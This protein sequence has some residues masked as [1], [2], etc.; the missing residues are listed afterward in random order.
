MG[1]RT[2]RRGTS[3]RRG[4]AAA[5]AA[6]ATAVVLATSGL[7]PA[8]AAEVDT[9]GTFGVS[10]APF[11]GS[12][13]MPGNFPATTFTSTSSA[14]TVISGASTWQAASTPVGSVFGSSRDRTYLTQRPAANNAASPAVTV[15]TFATPTPSSGWAFVLGDIDADEVT[16]SATGPGGA[17]VAVADLGYQESYNSCHRAG[18]PSCDAANLNDRPSWRDDG[19]TG[20]LLGNARAADTDGATAWF[21]PSVPIASLTM[22]YRWR[23]GFPIYQTWFVAKTFSAGGTVTLDDAPLAG[24]TVTVYDDAGTVVGTAVSGASGAWSLPLLI[25]T[26]PY[27]AVVAPPAGIAALADRTFSLTESDADAVDF[28][29]VTPPAPLAEVDA[30]STLQGI[31]V[32]HPLLDNDLPGSE[33]FPLVTDSVRF[34]VP[35][36]AP[37]GTVLSPD[38]RQLS[39]PGEG[40]WS[41]DPDGVATFAPEPAFTG[42]TTAVP[43]SV[44]DSRGGVATSTVTIEVAAVTPLAT[45]DPRATPMGQ[46]ER[47]RPWANDVAGDPSVPLVLESLAFV[48]PSDAPPGST[49]APDGK[50][51]V[52]PGEGT[53][54]IGDDFWV[55]FTPDPAFSGVAT[56]VPYTV[57]DTNGTVATADIV[58]TVSAANEPIGTIDEIFTLQ[59]TTASGPITANDAP[60]SATATFLP[61]SIQFSLPPSAPPGSSVSDDGRTLVIGGEGTYTLDPGTDFTVFTPDPAFVGTTTPAPYS[62]LDSEGRTATA[63]IVVHVTPVTPSLRP[64]AATT[65]QG[66]PLRLQPL[67]NDEPG[68]AAVPLRP[69]SVALQLPPGAPAGSSLSPDGVL[70]IAGEGTYTVTASGEVEFAPIP[71]FTG[72]ATPVPYTVTDANGT[73]AASVISIAVTPV[74]PNPSPDAAVTPQATAT[75]VDVLGNDLPGVDAVALD[76]ASVRLQV[77]SGAPAGTTLGADGRSLVVPGEGAYTVDPVSGVVG[78]VPVATF[79]GEATPVPYNVTDANGTSAS[80]VLVISVTPV[81]PVAGVDNVSAPFGSPTVIDVLGNDVDGNEADGGAPAPLVPGSVRLELPVGVDPGALSDDGRTL[82]L[83]GVG[84]FVVDPDSG[85]V[86]FTPA[87]G[88]SGLTPVVPYTVLDANGTLARSSILVDVAPAPVVPPSEPPVEPPAEPPAPGV[89]P[90]NP[91]APAGSTSGEAGGLPATGAWALTALP[92]AVLLLAG[93]VLA[94]STRRLRHARPRR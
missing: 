80:A 57:A 71:S 48:L 84:T 12:V 16:L 26:G 82:S 17:P 43:Y 25:A 46:P 51:L 35:P 24:A 50:T 21:A 6:V 36:G 5:L 70:T 19:A 49:L 81:T 93:G 86:T 76:P 32:S 42:L 77:P 37:A 53:Y 8:S 2:G 30:A 83:D 9:W 67:A 33:A 41:V 45:D 29:F 58:I 88:F 47:F 91:A 94:L 75:S 44:A 73:V 11:T 69:E 87:E 64:D 52:I 22:S 79:V 3:P 28:P 20:L 31:A 63:T 68:T 65:D 74:V 4:L 56:T 40:V 15:Y 34:T 1:V 23:S 90:G 55:T 38:G 60:S 59:G 10:A 13:A 7:T 92:A 62:V 72:D 61:D 66:T 18:G 54:A 89:V 14:A 27:R 39:I 85:A 78:F